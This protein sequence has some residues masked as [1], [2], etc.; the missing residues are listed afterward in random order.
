MNGWIDDSGINSG[1]ISGIISET[2][3]GIISGIISGTG[4]KS[5]KSGTGTGI[6]G[7]NPAH[8]AKKKVLRK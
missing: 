3:S 1:I 8:V 7:L 6:N 5:L 2:N 4:I